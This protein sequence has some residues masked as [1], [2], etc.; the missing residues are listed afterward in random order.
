MSRFTR[1]EFLKV[2]NR[3]L[4]ITGLGFILA[5]IVAYF[6]PPN[7]EETP[8]KPIPLGPMEDFP[9]G[10]SKTIRYGRYPALVINTPE[11]LRAYSAVCTH[12]AC[13][14]KWD[15][16]TGKIVCPCHDGLFN[17]LDGSVLSGPPPV[18]L[19][20]LPLHVSD[21]QIFLGGEA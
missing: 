19:T 13:I 10:E 14:V 8:S 21:G 16:E 11:G 4:T 12:F 9:V 15:D 20:S 6:Y 3:I 5:P 7:L 2:T 1:R 18:P 17:P